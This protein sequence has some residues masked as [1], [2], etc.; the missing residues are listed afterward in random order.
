[1]LRNAKIYQKVINILNK[2]N[3]MGN[4]C[5]LPQIPN[6][7][8][9]IPPGPHWSLILSW[10]T[11][12]YYVLIWR[13]VSRK[14]NAASQWAIGRVLWGSD[15]TTS[16]LWPAIWH[17]SCPVIGF[18]TSEEV[19]LIVYLCSWFTGVPSWSCQTFDWESSGAS[20]FVLVS[21]LETFVW[22]LVGVIAL[23]HCHTI[24]LLY[25]HTVVLYICQYMYYYGPEGRPYSNQRVRP[26]FRPF[27]LPS[28]RSSQ[29]I[30]ADG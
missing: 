7:P 4:D 25:C 21:L 27:V 8:L 15:G 14:V 6:P 13:G 30:F 12:R 28:V 9:A 20:C 24:A 18:P 10:F 19:S 11:F 29:I 1:M 26:S 16:D 23:S 5:H 2:I 22:W 3:E 17:V